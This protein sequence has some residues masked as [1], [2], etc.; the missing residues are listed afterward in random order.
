MRFFNP[1]VL[2][3]SLL[4]SFLLVSS[5]AN[6]LNGIPATL[7]SAGKQLLLN[8]AGERTKF[9]LTLYKAGLYLQKKNKSADNIM[10]ANQ[11]MALRLQILS[12]FISSE[13]MTHATKQGFANA[14]GGKTAPIQPQINQFLGAFKA[15]IKKGDIFE[16]AYA[17]AG[18]TKVIKNGKGITVI[19]GLPFKQALFGI[20]LSNRPAQV[21]LKN[22]LLGN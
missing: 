9:V 13:K 22:Q 11:V 14:T 18:G 8:G 1:I 15:P 5:Q 4:F 12:G 17:P 3:F 2:S 16:F 20:W 6:A 19:K 10:N 7:N 21:S